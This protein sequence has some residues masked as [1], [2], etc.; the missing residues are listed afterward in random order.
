MERHTCTRLFQCHD[1]GVAIARFL[2]VFW[3]RHCDVHKELTKA[4]H[5]KTMN[6]WYTG[7]EA[8]AKKRA[9]EEYKRSWD[10]N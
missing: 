5:G 6:G 3:G 2:S 8:K 1:F 9:K 4:K 10:P 7:A